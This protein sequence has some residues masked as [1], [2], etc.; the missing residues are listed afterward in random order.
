MD[1]SRIR[2]L[3][4]RLSGLKH[5]RADRSAPRIESRPA[6]FTVAPTPG[7]RSQC[8]STSCRVAFGT[9]LISVVPGFGVFG[10]GQIQISMVN[11]GI[12]HDPQTI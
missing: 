2:Y 7:R 4:A 12:M 5:S 1:G 3:S 9:Y 8:A 10:F 6:R 11:I